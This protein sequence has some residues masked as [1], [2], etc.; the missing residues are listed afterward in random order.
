MDDNHRGNVCCVWPVSNMKRVMVEDGIT[1]LE[2]G[3]IKPAQ[4]FA[5]IWCFRCADLYRW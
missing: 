1:S 5:E 3:L 4:K 2:F